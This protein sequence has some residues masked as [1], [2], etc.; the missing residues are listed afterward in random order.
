MPLNPNELIS[1][2]KER[3]Y[4]IQDAVCRLIA[5]EKLTDQ[6]RVELAKVAREQAL[7]PE[8]LPP[9]PPLVASSFAQTA[10]GVKLRLNTVSDVKGID[11]LNP[12]TPLAFDAPLSVVLVEP[13]SANLVSSGF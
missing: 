3:P 12:R 4:W 8:R 2:F 10:S 5:K 11:A 6:D 13:E 1:W 9:L 7:L